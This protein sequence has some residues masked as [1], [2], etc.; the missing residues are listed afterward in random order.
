MLTHAPT[1][2]TLEQVV[3]R[4]LTSR[5]ITRQDQHSLLHLYNLTTQERDLINRLFD[6]LRSGLIRVVD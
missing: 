5:K 3:A 1:A 6:R 4:I 2:D